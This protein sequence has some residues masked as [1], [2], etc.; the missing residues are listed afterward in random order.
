MYFLQTAMALLG[1]ETEWLAWTEFLQF[2]VLPSLGTNFLR[3][4]AVL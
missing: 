2:S 4:C 3:L 1:S